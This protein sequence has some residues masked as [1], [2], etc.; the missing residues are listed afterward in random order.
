MPSSNRPVAVID[1]GSNSVRLVIYEGP[2]RHASALHNEKAICAIGR[3]MV[4][5]G[6]LDEAGMEFALE[7]LGRFR[8][9]CDGHE[10]EDFGAV[11]TSAA[12]DAENGRDFI[13][14]AEK[15]LGQPI[16]ILS[17]EDEAKIAAEGT[18]AGIPDA[19]GLVAD[20]GGGSLDMVTV[21]DGK[22]GFAATLPFGPLRLMDLSGGNLNKA[23]NAVE[24]GLDK[25]D[26]AKSLKGR[27]LYAVGGIW[28]ALAHVDME[29]SEYPVRVLHH[30]A[31][32]AEIGRAHV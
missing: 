13:R 18:L 14:R 9:L 31:I 32:P 4:S 30:Y 19:N 11:A 27:A 28:R 16:Q 12:R 3:N 5:T 8:A 15:I 20:L 6:R 17:G 26:L 23:R 29:Q 22:T 2:W 24:K 25:L 1:I 7:T 10:V 21:K